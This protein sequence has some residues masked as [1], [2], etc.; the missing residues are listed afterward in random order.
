MTEDGN[1]GTE[2]MDVSVYS[3]VEGEYY[4]ETE[5]LKSGDHLVIEDTQE[6]YTVSKRATLIGVF[7][8]NKGYA[9]FRQIEILYQNEEYAIVKPNTSYGLRVYDLIV[10]DASSVSAD[11]FIYK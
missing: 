6:T 11:Q 10:Q 8:M 2:Y 1:R 4:V 3:I 9:D 5:A 7:N